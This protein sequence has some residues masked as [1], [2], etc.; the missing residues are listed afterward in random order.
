MENVKIGGRY[1]HF[2]GFE[3]TVLDIAKHTETGEELVIY[4]HNANFPCKDILHEGKKW[5]R[6]AEMFFDNVGTAENPKPRFEYL[7]QSSDPQE[8]CAMKE[9]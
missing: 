8:L 2:K 4:A 6:P 9:E 1:R 5:A 7:G 3:I